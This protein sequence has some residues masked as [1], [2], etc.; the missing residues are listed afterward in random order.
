MMSLYS[1]V[2]SLA[3]SKLSRYLSFQSS[4]RSVYIILVLLL[5]CLSTQ[6]STHFQ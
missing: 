4:D 6:S 3:A 5:A 1:L 2:V